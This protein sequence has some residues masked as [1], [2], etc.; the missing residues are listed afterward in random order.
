MK[1]TERGRLPGTLSALGSPV[2]LRTRDAGTDCL[3]H[4]GRT[5]LT[6]LPFQRPPPTL[7]LSAASLWASRQW[8]GPCVLDLGQ[9]GP[10]S[11]SLSLSEFLGLPGLCRGPGWEPCR[12][13][14]P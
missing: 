9:E 5:L 13:R 3:F 6:S 11:L 10:T 2:P 12:N 4:L 7:P 8:C 14:K 1:G